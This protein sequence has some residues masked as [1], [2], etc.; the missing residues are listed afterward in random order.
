MG[1]LG[2]SLVLAPWRSTHG[3][4]L[5]GQL[6]C[7]GA[8]ACY[9]VGF[10]WT[11]RFLTGVGS[12]PALAAAQLLCAMAEFAVLTPF[13]ATG[14]MSLPPRVWLSLLGLGAAATGF[15]YVNLLRPDP[16]RGRDDRLDRARR[17]G[18]LERLRRR[19]RRDLGHRRFRGAAAVA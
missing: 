11:R 7:L 4:H 14:H 19:R 12:P 3:A 9:G 16:R 17:S 15:A 2:V 13:F 18:A 1:F 6:A 10:A 8:G 5:A